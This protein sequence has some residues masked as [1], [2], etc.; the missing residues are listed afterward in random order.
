MSPELPDNIR[1]LG[2][3]ELDKAVLRVA[4]MSEFDCINT[5][6]QILTLV[7]EGALRE[8]LLRI[9]SEDKS[10]AADLQDMLFKRDLLDRKKP[11]EEIPELE[12]DHFMQ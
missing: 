12:E 11:A 10:H 7:G 3:E 5:Y 8:D 9:L 1:M 6:E 4:I 2:K